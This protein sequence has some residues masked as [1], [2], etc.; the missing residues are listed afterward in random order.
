MLTLEMKNRYVSVHSDHV[1]E[2][3][4]LNNKLKGR[5][6]LHVCPC[7][8]VCVWI[9]LAAKEGAEKYGFCRTSF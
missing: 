7:V 3:C 5:L 8:C 9:L 6:L 4:I 1:A 2:S